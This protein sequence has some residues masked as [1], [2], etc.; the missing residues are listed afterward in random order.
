MAAAKVVLR[1]AFNDTFIVGDLVVTQDGTEVA[2]RKQA[3]DVIETARRAGV[4][5]Y[6]VPADETPKI[7]GSGS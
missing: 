3:D 4:T 6:E 2:S 5:L 1:T 7:E